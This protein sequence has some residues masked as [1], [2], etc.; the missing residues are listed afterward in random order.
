MRCARTAFSRVM[1]P[2][3]AGRRFEFMTDSEARTLAPLRI[4]C[5]EDNPLIVF[6]LE[7]MLEDMGHIFAGS[8]ES[9]SALRAQAD[10]IAVDGALVDIDLS[11]G[12]TGPQA[13]S[14]L[15]ERRIPTIF[16][17]G[18]ERIAAQHAHL[19]VG[20]IVKPISPP[21]LA[22]RIELFRNN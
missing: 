12:R 5:L 2:G 21:E 11:D 9:F 16:V 7:H 18:Q 22:D 14:W 17:T 8:A 15:R 3:A 13:A 10:P 1:Q 6:H 20:I 4:F 19:S